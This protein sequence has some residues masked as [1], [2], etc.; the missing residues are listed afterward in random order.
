CWRLDLGILTP[1]AYL[2]CLTSNLVKK[3]SSRV[4]VHNVQVC[5]ICIRVPCWRAVPI[6]S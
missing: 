2:K 5:Y 6:N 4:H 3:N 1:Q